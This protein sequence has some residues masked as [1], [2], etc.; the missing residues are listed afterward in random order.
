MLGVTVCQCFVQ[1]EADD[2]Y[3][4]HT[5][6]L[7]YGKAPNSKTFIK[8]LEKYPTEVLVFWDAACLSQ[9]SLTRVD[10]YLIATDVLE[11]AVSH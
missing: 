11:W 2:A 10:F 5:S 3:V 6:R 8:N 4:K 7:T 9:S 1:L